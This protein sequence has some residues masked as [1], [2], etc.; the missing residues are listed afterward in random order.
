[1]K[2]VNK[3]PCGLTS[4]DI[5]QNNDFKNRTKFVEMTRKGI[6]SCTKVHLHKQYIVKQAN[7]QIDKKSKN[8]I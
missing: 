3:L 7:I 1:M 2:K 6:F 5:S 8:T 4:I